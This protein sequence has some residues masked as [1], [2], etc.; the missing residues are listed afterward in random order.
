M[1]VQRR[2]KREIGLQG[3]TEER[4]HVQKDRYQFRPGQKVGSGVHGCPLNTCGAQQ[5]FF[6]DRRFLR[7]GKYFYGPAVA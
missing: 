5:P 4:V 3:Q 2:A 1:Y 6:H 7:G